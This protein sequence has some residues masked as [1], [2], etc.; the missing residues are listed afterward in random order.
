MAHRPSPQPE[1]TTVRPSSRTLPIWK[2]DGLR[3]L[4]TEHSPSTAPATPALRHAVRRTSGALVN[5]CGRRW[6]DTTSSTS[7]TA[8]LSDLEE[9]ARPECNSG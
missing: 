6:W 7:Y 4:V 3:L 9:F 5:H 2:T 8:C 1:I